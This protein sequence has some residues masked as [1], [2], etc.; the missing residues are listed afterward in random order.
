MENKELE[1]LFE[2]KRTV[3][4]N[5]RRQEKLAAMIASETKHTRPLWPVWAGAVAAGIAIVLITLPALFRTEA[6]API[7]VAQTEMPEVTVQPEA[8]P[9]EAT[10]SRPKRK[11]TRKAE[12]TETLE[13]IESTETIDNIEPMESIEFKNHIEAIQPTEPVPAAPRVHRRSSTLLA[14]TE[15]CTIVTVPNIPQTQ[16]TDIPQLLADAFGSKSNEPFTVKT[17]ELQ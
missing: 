1:Q 4:A 9:E 8:T 15:G 10:A 16:N 17:F 5:R 7:L 13:E 11:A 3:E 6:D 2:A 14:C 12:T